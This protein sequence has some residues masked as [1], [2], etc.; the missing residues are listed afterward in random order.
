MNKEQKKS[1]LRNRKGVTIV[2]VV[3]A[4]V[5]ISVISASAVDLIMRA[6]RIENNF[7]TVTQAEMQAENVLDCFRFSDNDATFSQ[8][9]KKAGDYKFQPGENAYILEGKT[10]KI[11]VKASF[12]PKTLAYT[13]EKYNGEQI[14]SFSYPLAGEGGAP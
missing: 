10:I 11:I 14:Y 1:G 9:L 13:A 12:S 5:I 6:L 2:E 7:T 4:L 8:A 3:I